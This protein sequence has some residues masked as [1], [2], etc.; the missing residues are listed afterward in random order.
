MLLRTL[1][2][3]ALPCLL[4]GQELDLT[5]SWVTDSD[6]AKIGKQ[7][8]LRKLNLS[9]TKVTDFGMEYLKGLTSVT[10]LDCRFAEFLTDDAVASI[11][12]WKQLERLNLR[13]TQVTSK[14]FEHLAQLTNLRWLDLSHT[15]IEDEGF[16]YLAALTKLEHLAIGSTRLNGSGLALLKPLPA[17]VSLDLSGIQRVD[18]GLW[19]L[20]LTHENLTRIGQLAQLRRLNLSGATIADRGID[21]PGSPD[22][23]RSELRDLSPLAALKNLEALDLSRLPITGE[24]LAPLRGLPRLRGLRLG[25]APKID[26]EAAKLLLAM[27]Q[28]QRVYLSGTRVSPDMMG[29]LEAKLFR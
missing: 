8:D 7:K 27:P 1:L 18:S 19:G 23:E 10:D 5:S 17:L 26:D 12:G 3:S 13:G 28:L 9:D 16:E 24:S 20:P 14:V 6:L 21:R 22:A 4:F 25:L 15:Q 2:L 29:K 11:R